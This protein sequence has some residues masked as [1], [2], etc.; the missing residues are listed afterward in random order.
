[1][2]SWCAISTIVCLIILAGLAFWLVE[3]ASVNRYYTLG[4]LICVII[5]LLVSLFYCPVA[6]EATDNSVVIKRT[7]WRK[8][9][10]YPMIEEA[11]LCPPTMGE[12][13]I[14][15]SGGFLGHW[16]WHSEKDLG[17]YFAYYGKSSECF[18]LKLMDGRQYMLSCGRPERMVEYIRTRIS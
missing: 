6:V 13:R 3:D 12:R 15:G 8:V 18:L 17:R 4:Y 11:R 16:G 7:L 9:I 14:C 10:P 1:M 2:S 5:F